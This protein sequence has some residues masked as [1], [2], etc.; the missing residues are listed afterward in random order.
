VY[1][2]GIALCQW[3]LANELK[4][5]VYAL[6]KRSGTDQWLSDQLTRAAASA[7]ANIAEGF[8][9]FQPKEFSQFLRIA[10]GS[11]MEVS[12]HLTDG[13]DRGCFPSADTEPLLTL[14]RR[15]SAATTRLIR[16]LRTAK[17]PPARTSNP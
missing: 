15:A 11:L 7:T 5:G 10:N 13:V 6:V 14:A 4:I 17:A 9:R 8:G 2:A 3:R 16:Y 12:N 1:A